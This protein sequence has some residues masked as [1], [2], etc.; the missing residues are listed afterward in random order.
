MSCLNTQLQDLSKIN[1]IRKTAAVLSV[2][3]KERNQDFPSRSLAGSIE[4]MLLSFTV[5]GMNEKPTEQGRRD[6]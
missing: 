1:S 4:G 5:I 2:A 3:Y 6:Y